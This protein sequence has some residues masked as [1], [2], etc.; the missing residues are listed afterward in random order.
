MNLFNKIFCSEFE[1]RLYEK[2]FRNNCIKL[3][4][5]LNEYLGWNIKTLKKHMLDF[6]KNMSLSSFSCIHEKQKT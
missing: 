5:Q 6:K 4:V 1:N 3:A 2:P